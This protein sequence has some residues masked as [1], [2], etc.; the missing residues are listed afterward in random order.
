[1]KVKSMTGNGFSKN[2]TMKT[3]KIKSDFVY[4]KTLRQGEKLDMATIEKIMD[5]CMKTEL[6]CKSF[7]SQKRMSIEV[8][9]CEIGNLIY[10]RNYA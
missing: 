5:S 9:V 8:L 2:E 1:M 4:K 10:E 7:S 6:K 3:L